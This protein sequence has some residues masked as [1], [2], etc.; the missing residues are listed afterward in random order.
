VGERRKA[1]YRSDVI[2]NPNT[3]KSPGISD[4]ISRQDN[5][6][7]PHPPE[8][9]GTDRSSND[10]IRPLLGRQF[11]IEAKFIPVLDSS[12]SSPKTLKNSRAIA[13]YL[14]T[15]SMRQLEYSQKG[16]IKAPSDK[17]NIAYEAD[18]CVLRNAKFLCSG[19]RYVSQSISRE[20]QVS[21]GFELRM[22]L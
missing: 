11:T 7:I 19:A 6:R 13:Q 14:A 4:L 5:A 17:T 1:H 12:R 20:W 15:R 9:K 3:P 10:P 8:L 18:R 22:S 2:R 21:Y 16:S